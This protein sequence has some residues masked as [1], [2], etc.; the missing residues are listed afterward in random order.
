[1]AYFKPR[2]YRWGRESGVLEYRIIANSQVIT[3]GGFVNLVSGFVDGADAGERIW[4]L[5]IGFVVAPTNLPSSEFRSGGIPLDKLTAGTDYD[6][7][8]VSGTL[9]TQKYTASGDNQTDKKVRAVIDVSPDLV[10]SNV[11]DA[12]IGTTAGSELAGSWTDLVTDVQVDENNAG[13]AFTT[14]AQLVILGLDP[15]DT[16]AGLYM[17]M[18]NQASGG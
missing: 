6:G 9:G 17:I 7:T 18:E 13:N 2:F 11:P 12:T 4:G 3:T 10:V 14:I 15:E 16:T 8:Y 1:M 5:C